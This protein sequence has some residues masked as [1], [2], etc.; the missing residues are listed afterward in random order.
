[1]LKYHHYVKATSDTINGIKGTN[2][3]NQQ[4]EEKK[5]KVS[6][7]I[8]TDKPVVPLVNLVVPVNQPESALLP[9]VDVLQPN[10][11]LGTVADRQQ[12]VDMGQIVR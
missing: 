2:F 11:I 12:K 1:M 9:A 3:Q 5:S 7:T 8:S 10:P 6:G 4:K